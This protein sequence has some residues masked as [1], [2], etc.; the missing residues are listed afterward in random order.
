MSYSIDV[1]TSRSFLSI[2]EQSGADPNWLLSTTVQASAALVGIV[3][4]FLISRLVSL[5]TEKASVTRQQASA[6][7]AAK[8]AQ[9]RASAARDYRIDLAERLL[10]DSSLETIVALSPDVQLVQIAEHNCPR[11]TNPRD[12][13]DFVSTLAAHVARLERDV[14]AAVGDSELPYSVAELQDDFDIQIEDWEERIVDLVLEKLNSHVQEVLERAIPLRAVSVQSDPLF[15]R[16]ELALE[17]E[18]LATADEDTTSAVLGVAEVALSSLSYPSEMRGALWVLTTFA[19]LGIVYPSIWLAVGPSALGATVRLTVIGAFLVGVALLI[20]YLW[21][22]VFN[23]TRSN[24]GIGADHTNVVK[25]G[26]STRGHG[27]RSHTPD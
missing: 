9:E 10:E 6:S 2:S 7:V 15:E 24:S 11:G 3:A 13:V 14:V 17:R 23:L 26:S 19:A 8:L 1:I 22:T 16:Y 27:G 18:R 25:S 12:L 5:A 20:V 21:L 4:A